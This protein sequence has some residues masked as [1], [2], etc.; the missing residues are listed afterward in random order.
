MG[1]DIDNEETVE[2]PKLKWY[3]H[4]ER[5]NGQPWS[6]M[7][8]HGVVVLNVTRSTHPILYDGLY[9]NFHFGVKCFKT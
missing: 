7:V 1:I 4:V 3:G 2:Y 9:G 6:K 8:L 5:E